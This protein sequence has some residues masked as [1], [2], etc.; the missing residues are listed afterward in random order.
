MVASMVLLCV[1]DQVSGDLIVV[2]VHSFVFS[3]FLSFLAV[4]VAYES[5][6]ARG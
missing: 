6:Q 1:G 5:S 3:F 4:A 2:F